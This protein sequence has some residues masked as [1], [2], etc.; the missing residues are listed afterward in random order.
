MRFT[1]ALEPIFGVK[2]RL[3]MWVCSIRSCG[4]STSSSAAL[5]AATTK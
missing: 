5:Q 4:N 3:C 1:P 2:M